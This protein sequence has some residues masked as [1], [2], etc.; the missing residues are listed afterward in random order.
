MGID[1]ASF[2][3]KDKK[4]I[5]VAFGLETVCVGCG[6]CI[7]VCP[8]NALSFAPL[9]SGRWGVVTKTQLVQIGNATQHNPSRS[10]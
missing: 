6:G 5:E 2:A 4:P 3:H 8:V 10:A 9:S 7:D 1:V